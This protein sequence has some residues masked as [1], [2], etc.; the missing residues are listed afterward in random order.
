MADPWTRAGGVPSVLAQIIAP[1]AFDF[2]ILSSPLGNLVI[3]KVS[4]T[5]DSDA[6]PVA[7]LPVF[8]AC[9]HDSPP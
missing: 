6:K 2:T 1:P 3:P 8:G 7:G 9:G 4:I 5:G